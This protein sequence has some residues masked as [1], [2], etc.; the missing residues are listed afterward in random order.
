MPIPVGLARASRDLAKRR[1]SHIIDIRGT[2]SV[3][4]PERT[5]R[6]L[7][8]FQLPATAVDSRDSLRF[9]GIPVYYRNSRGSFLEMGI[10]GN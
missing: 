2:C 5:H 10:P 7:N 4:C 8:K 6:P 1:L 9:P 3:D